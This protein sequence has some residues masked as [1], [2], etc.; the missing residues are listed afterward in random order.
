MTISLIWRN[1]FSAGIVR[2]AKASITRLQQNRLG[3]LAP[4][5]DKAEWYRTYVRY[6]AEKF[7][8]Q[9]VAGYILFTTLEVWFQAESYGPRARLSLHV[10]AGN[11]PRPFRELSA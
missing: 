1:L 10:A 5:T 7:F 8:S 6:R 2:Q 11:S 3:I 4:A 9:H